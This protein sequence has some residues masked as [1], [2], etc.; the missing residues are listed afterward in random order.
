VT[1][2]NLNA[3]PTVS[4]HLE[5]GRAIKRFDL[6]MR[7][8]ENGNAIGLGERYNK[9]SHQ[10]KAMRRVRE[11]LGS[12]R[13]VMDDD[14]CGALP[15]SDWRATHFYYG[16]DDVDEMATDKERRVVGVRR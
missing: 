1:K 14:V 8:M 15:R 3:L 4:E 5:F 2:R 6:A 11:A 7:Q 9:T 13:S 16:D 12:L 10:A